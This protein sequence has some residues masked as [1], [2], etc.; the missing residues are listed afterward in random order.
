M[1]VAKNLKPVPVRPMDG[2]VFTWK[3]CFLRYK[4]WKFRPLEVSKTIQNIREYSVIF[5]NIPKLPGVLWYVPELNEMFR[6]MPDD[7]GTFQNTLKCS[8]TLWTT[9]RLFIARL[10]SQQSR[11]RIVRT[12]ETEEQLI[13]RI[14]ESR[15]ATQRKEDCERKPPMKT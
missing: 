2:S 4:G 12:R 11:I 3:A 9:R 5:Q 10:K 8:G 1:R 13:E 14:E 15:F 7:R 6:N